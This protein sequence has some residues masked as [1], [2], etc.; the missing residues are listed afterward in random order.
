[1]PSRYT[2]T[3]AQAYE[4][5]M[6]RWSPLLA[7]QL[8]AWA[9]IEAGDRVLDVGCGTGSLALA[10]AARPEPAEIVGIDEAAEEIPDRCGGHPA[11]A[12]DPPHRAE[13]SRRGGAPGLSGGYPD[14]PRSKAATAWAARGIAPGSIER[15][16][17]G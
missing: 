5:L 16:E 14:G 11:P 17:R 3:D 7:Q 6:G 8:I 2:A 13:Q 1:M 9:G 4:R 12:R 15:G 10:F